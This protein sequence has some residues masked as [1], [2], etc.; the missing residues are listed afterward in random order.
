MFYAGADPGKSFTYPTAAGEVGKVAPQGRA[1]ST[2]EGLLAALSGLGQRLK[3]AMEATRAWQW[4]YDVL[5]DQGLEVTLVH[6]CKTR[7]IASARR[8]SDRPDAHILAQ[9]LR[10]DLFGQG[11]CARPPD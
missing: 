4:A 10:A 5:S 3:V 6:P 8:G 1:E 2:P 7:A 11:L 9:L